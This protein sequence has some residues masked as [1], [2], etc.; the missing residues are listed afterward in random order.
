MT[1]FE[2]LYRA[3]ADP[4]QVASAWYECRKRA[5]L[6]ASL[7][8]QRYG[9]VLEL[10]CGTGIT[11][12]E[13]AQRCDD[14][15]A[16]DSAPTAVSRCRAVLE[17][18]GLGHARVEEG[19]LPRA[20]PV[21][22]GATVDLIVVSE[23]AYYFSDADLTAFLDHCHNSLA[24]GADWLLCH[25]KRPFHDRMQDTDALHRRAGALPGMR[26]LI[27]HDEDDFRLD[28]WRAAGGS[29]S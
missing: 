18:A 1:D 2:A 9:R 23:L 19:E 11:T 14:L 26:H 4:W 25:Y 27:A 6:M 20:W 15:L 3:D 10:G 29:A 22:P 12:R 13:L 24:P 16:I 28:V 21:T 7:P 5:L 8:Q 17:A